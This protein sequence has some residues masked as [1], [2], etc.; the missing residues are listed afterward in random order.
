MTDDPPSNHIQAPRRSWL[1]ANWLFLLVV[2]IA[3]GILAA[4]QA[5]TRTA[6]VPPSFDETVTLDVARARAEQS[7]RPVLALATA[8]WCAYCQKLK[9]GPLTDER[10]VNL[11]STR[12]EPAYVDITDERDPHAAEAARLLRIG[13]IPTLILIQDDRELARLEGA[14]STTKLI[15]WLTNN[16]PPT[17]N[18]PPTPDN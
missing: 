5:F 9:R 3:I 16:L 14:V 17:K 6:P 10:I 8:D 13:P 2:C 11:I 18:D 15:T 7:H 1:R 12:T 4:R